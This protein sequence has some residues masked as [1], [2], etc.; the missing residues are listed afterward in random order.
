MIRYLVCML[1]LASPAAA[2]TTW[3]HTRDAAV[4]GRTHSCSLY[5]YNDT[6]AVI[7]TWNVDGAESL[8]LQDRQ[9]FHFPDND[10]VV[11][12]L[13]IDKTLLPVDAGSGDNDL[14]IVPIQPI[15][16]LLPTASEI[17]ATVAA[18]HLDTADLTMP[19][20][21]AKMPVLLTA[22]GKCRTM[23]R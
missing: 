16:N 9:R 19:V 21:T 6:Q 17:S 10:P 22:V 7:I 12:T 15:D 23:L 8:A 3:W 1:M 5:F 4:I 2:D 20:N 13:H 11:V 18:A 14:V